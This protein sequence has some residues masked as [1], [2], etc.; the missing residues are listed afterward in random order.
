MS[1]FVCRP[2]QASKAS[3]DPGPIPRNLSVEHRGSRPSFARTPPWGYGSRLCG[4]D[5]EDGCTRLHPDPVFEQ[6]Q[7][8]TRVRVLA[9]ASARALLSI[10]L[11]RNRRA[12]G[13]PVA[14]CTRALAQR[15]IARAREP[16]VQAVTTGLPCAVVYG[17]Y[18]LSSVNHPVCH[19]RR[20]RCEKHRKP[21]WR[22]TSGRQ[23]HTTSPSANMPHVDRQARVHRILAHAS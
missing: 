14:A 20:P 19:R 4:R 8:K 3:A 2:G 17:L 6:Q 10:A 16:Q 5:D 7:E 12:H 11:P 13:R 9:T 22:R 18:V 23:D 21:T 1:F 15:K